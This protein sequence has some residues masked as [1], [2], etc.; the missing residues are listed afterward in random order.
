TDSSAPTGRS[1]NAHLAAAVTGSG[2][3]SALWPRCGSPAGTRSCAAARP[4]IPP[5][6]SS[7]RPP[8]CPDRTGR[9]SRCPTERRSS[10]AAPSARCRCARSTSW[11]G[12]WRT[13]ALAPTASVGGRRGAARRGAHAQSRLDDVVD[14]IAA[15]ADSALQQFDGTGAEDLGALL[16]RG[17][18]GAG[19]TRQR[20]IVVAD[21]A[22]RLG[23]LVPQIGSGG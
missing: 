2:R 15:P 9:P 13:D 21:D 1:P 20:R 5:S 22:D 18:T 11:S 8:G 7:S 23:H 6:P 16:D 12:C 19:P 14:V 17:Q 10:A 4:G 3:P